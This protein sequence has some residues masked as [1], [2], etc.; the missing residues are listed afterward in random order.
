MFKKTVLVP[1]VLAGLLTLNVWAKDSQTSIELQQHAPEDLSRILVSILPDHPRMLAAKN[2]L[3]A[4]ESRLQA[5]D[6]P[7]YN[8]ELEIDSENTDINTSFLQLSQTI[9]S[10]GQRKARKRV[11][12][13]EINGAK[14]TYELEKLSLLKDLL[15]AMADEQSG[16][17]IAKL[18]S[19]GLELMRQFADIAERRF[20]AGDLS[21][22]E[23]DLAQLAFNQALMSHAQSLSDAAEARERMM[24]LFQLPPDQVPGLP[25]SL[26]SPALPQAARLDNFLDQLPEIEVIRMEVSALRESVS[27]R[28]SERSW[29]P[30]IAIRGGREDEESL[31]G[32]S[33][34][35]PLKIR[36]NQ[37]AEVQTARQELARSEQ[38]FLQ[39]KRNVRAR[40]MS[41]TERYRLLLTAFKAWQKNG[42]SHVDRQLKSINRL[43]QSGDMSTAEYLVQV[44]QALE[45]QTAGIELRNQMWLSSF[46]WMNNT[47]SID[48]WLNMTNTGTEK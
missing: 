31:V 37:K 33:L 20:K 23:T 10:G 34:S 9:D 8:P 5:A 24:A 16:R 17:E 14:A 47:A 41:S 27:L 25:E 36:N 30:T 22:V 26:P 40:I 18:A 29:E 11:A 21:Q 1:A 4:S 2:A 3:L 28:E 39:K 35:L 32:L 45:T 44:K 7:L 43:W 19:E 48:D 38:I 12:D 42:R 6:R 13:S 46:D 15:G